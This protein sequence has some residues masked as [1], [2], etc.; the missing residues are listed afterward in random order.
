MNIDTATVCRF[1]ITHISLR[2]YTIAFDSTPSDC[3]QRV[4][5]IDSRRR[6]AG[7]ESDNIRSLE[8]NHVVTMSPSEYTN[9]K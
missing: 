3:L 9:E 2:I 1:G 6:I 7:C 4:S 8:N 5:L